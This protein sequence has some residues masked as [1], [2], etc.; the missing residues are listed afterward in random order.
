[1]LAKPSRVAVDETAVKIGTEQYWLYAAIDI[2]TK[3]LLGGRISNRHGTAPAAVFL[4][5]A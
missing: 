5:Q 3:L 2:K 1:M 4:G